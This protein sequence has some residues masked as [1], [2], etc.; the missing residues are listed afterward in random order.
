MGAGAEIAREGVVFPKEPG[1]DLTLVVDGHNHPKILS[2][3][4]GDQAKAIPALYREGRDGVHL[5]NAQFL[6]IDPQLA[7]IIESANSGKFSDA[8]RTAWTDYYRNSHLAGEGMGNG[9]VS[10][11]A[12]EL[13]SS[14][15][16]V[17]TDL[18]ING[19]NGEYH[20]FVTLLRNRN[21]QETT[22]ASAWIEKVRDAAKSG[23]PLPDIPQNLREYV[24]DIGHHQIPSI[25]STAFNRVTADL[26][27]GHGI[28]DE[29]IAKLRDIA[30]RLETPDRSDSVTLPIL[31]DLTSRINTAMGYQDANKLKLDVKVEPDGT[32][33]YLLTQVLAPVKKRTFLTMTA[34]YPNR[35]TN[36]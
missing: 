23:Q 29:G 9:I 26:R 3:L 34:L 36:C 7:D 25:L 35:S 5:L 12:T 22:E 17:K 31:R 4:K 18:L 6:Q 19:S 32:Q 27:A 16:N 20:T 1:S 24:M 21:N 14:D 30:K 28:T 8:S 13:T 15:L 33:H 2:I 11:F 10:D